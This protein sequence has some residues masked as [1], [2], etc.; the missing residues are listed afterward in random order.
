MPPRTQRTTSNLAP[1]QQ[2]R[3]CA[4]TTADDPSQPI[5]T[6]FA[7][8]EDA[9]NYANLDQA[10]YLPQQVVAIFNTNIFSEACH[11]WHRCFIAQ[12]TWSNFKTNFTATHHDLR[13][14]QTTTHS[15][16]HEKVCT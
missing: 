7:Q 2:H 10:P 14:A 12:H 8:T 16:S 11:D 6:L 5:E 3:C 9:V 15:G 13:L 1:L 4:Q